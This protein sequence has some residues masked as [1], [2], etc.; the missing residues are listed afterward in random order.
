MSKKALYIR[1]RAQPGKREEVKRIW[2][3]Y[4]RAYIEGANGHVAYVYGF[5]DNDPDAI[6]AYQ[7]YTDEAGTDDFVKQPWYPDYERETAALLAG[8]S[9]FRTITPQWTKGD[10]A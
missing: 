5:D 2:E 6:V 3:K 4:A 10:A 8:P 9:E 7:L 1:H